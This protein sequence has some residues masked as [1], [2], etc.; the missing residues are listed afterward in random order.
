MKV[1]SPL[2]DRVLKWS[3]HKKAPQILGGLS[4][5]ESSF[6]PIPPDVMLAPMT[7]AQPDKAWRFA[8]ITTVASVLG[9]ILGYLIG[10][11]GYDLVEPFFAKIHYTGK[12][13]IARS[14]FNEW[15]VWV[16]F[17]AGFTPI[18]YKIFTILAGALNMALIP[19]LIAS[20]IGRGA[21]FFLVAGIIKLGGEKM[22]RSLRQYIDVLGWLVIV[23]LIAAY[24]ILR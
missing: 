9:A 21:R 18:P 8:F 24:F 7:L 23:A 1:F 11:F 5:I 22:E 3:T 20:F 13:D 6:F 12:V 19:F 17:I 15:G 10:M 16:V 4:F 2:Y 14:W